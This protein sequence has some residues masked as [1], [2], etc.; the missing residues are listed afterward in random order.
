MPDLSWNT[1]VEVVM[2]HSGTQ[3]VHG[4]FAALILLMD[5]WP[6]MSGPAYAMAR[7]SCRASLDGRTTPEDARD[8]F[9]SAAQEAR[10]L[11]Q[12]QLSVA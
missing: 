7:S 4:P 9:V 6:T 2:P 1:P 12:A 8:R 10:L 3:T 11:P 5:E